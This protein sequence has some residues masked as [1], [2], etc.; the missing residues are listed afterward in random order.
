[1]FFNNYKYFERL[2][3]AE[4]TY[5]YILFNMCRDINPSQY[6]PTR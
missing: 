6:V 5:G 2:N 4:T 3:L 1:M